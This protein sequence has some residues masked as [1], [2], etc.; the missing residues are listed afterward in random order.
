MFWHILMIIIGTLLPIM[1]MKI[2]CGQKAEPTLFSGIVIIFGMLIGGITI[3]ALGWMFLFSG[4]LNLTET[5]SWFAEL[6]TSLIE[7]IVIA[8]SVHLI[9]RKSK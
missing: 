6:G 4:D 2:V 3:A 5:Q 9:A 7:G 8:S 1:A